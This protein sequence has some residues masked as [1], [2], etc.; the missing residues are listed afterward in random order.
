VHSSTL[1]NPEHFTRAGGI[2]VDASGNEYITG[3]V[4]DENPRA[5]AI[6]LAPSTR[7]EEG[8]ASIS[9][10]GAWSSETSP[11][12]AVPFS[13]GSAAVSGSAGSRATLRFN[14][15]GFAWV[16]ARMQTGGVAAVTVDGGAPHS[17]DLWWS[18]GERPRDIP[19]FTATG[20]EPGEHTVTIEVTG[21]ANEG[22]SGW[23]VWVDAFEVVTVPVSP[24]PTPTPLP[25][26]TPSG[27]FEQDDPRVAYTGSWPTN[28][29]HKHSGGTARLSSQIGDRVTVTFEGTGIRWI[30]LKDPWSGQANL[31]LDNTQRGTVETFSA[32]EQAQVPIV[33]FTGLAPGTHTLEITVGGQRNPASG[34]YAVWIDAFEVFT[35]TGTPTP[36]APP[37]PTPTGTPTAT[38]TPTLTPTPTP[39]A[40]PPPSTTRVEQDAAAAGYTGNWYPHGGG[41]SGGTAVLAGDPGSRATLSFS[42]T[43]VR[44]IGI[45]DSWSGIARVF[46][47]GALQATIDT[48]APTEQRQLVMY[49]R[50]GLAPGA[51][52]L[53][54]EVTGERNASSG[55]AWIW[56]DAFDVTT[57]GGPT[58]TPTPTPTTGPTPTPTPPPAAQT[59]QQDDARVV[60]SGPWYGH[61]H[62]VHIGGS[63]ITAV[64]TGAAVQL[65]FSGTG[66]RWIGLKD[67]WCGIARVY[68]D[69]TLRATVDTYSAME[70]T[71]VVL[72]ELTG[73]SSGAHAVRVEVTG[74]RGG[75]S[76][77]ASV[78]V[79]AFEV[80][81]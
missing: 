67:P 38:P 19:M 3:G 31:K 35:N 81:P 65:S 11:E 49:A 44:W 7:Y 69:G 13:G 51:H 24:V 5:L 72:Y 62:S 43:G 40:T 75:D 36:T 63:A 33:T 30:G 34:G 14:G 70:Q 61:V 48:Y 10:E 59:I 50:S 26:P 78:W 37:T 77:N 32:I 74:Q 1:G 20:L 73:M 17:I 9:Y 27:R 54:I 21:V 28:S 42:G 18:N 39:S 53:A 76:G 46:I 2:V 12:A 8:H 4:D 15:T 80:L 66:V 79:D 58:P 25:T 56:V 64:D 57:T 60:Q 71:R 55:G 23:N 41:H 52:T 45:K 6:K 68:V 29:Y 16:S 47:D 22:S